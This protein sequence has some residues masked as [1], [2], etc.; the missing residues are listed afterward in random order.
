MNSKI[1]NASLKGKKERYPE[2]DAL[3]GLS[4]IS[5]IL[6]HYTFAYDNYFKSFSISRF[7]FTY[8]SLAVHLFFI[9]SGFVIFMTLERSKAKM[10][11]VVSRFSR[12][13][14]VYWGC[15]LLTLGAIYLL[16]IP[17]IH[18]FTFR[19]ILINMTMLQEFMKTPS[20]DDVYWTLKIELL[21]YMI[22]YF[23]YVIRKL[24][25]INY[26]SYLWL[27]I[28]TLSSFGLIPFKK[29][30][31]LFFILEYAPLFVAGINFYILKKNRGNLFNHLTIGYSL[32][33]ESKWLYAHPERGLSA[34]LI[35]IC[36]YLLFY[37]FLYDRLSFLNHRVL[38]FLGG[39]SYSLYLIH[40]VI[41]FSIIYRVRTFTDIQL[42]YLIVPFIISIL[43]ATLMT[44]FIEKPSISFIRN[45]YKKLKL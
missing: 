22:M 44:K 4:V 34:V 40:N 11:F 2:L 29:Y 28:S 26:I 13:Y 12:L 7:Y 32:L 25:H 31:D 15:M 33:I 24:N 18:N 10:D 3:R 16:P 41:G 42:L 20:I 37:L 35:I 6:F 19:E 43:L 9:I 36:V 27:A 23:I 38:V 8:G 39:I 30:L 17:G 5:V 21:F 1:N 14:P 45:Y